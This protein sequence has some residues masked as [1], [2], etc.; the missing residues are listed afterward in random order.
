MKS[1]DGV[2]ATSRNSGDISDGIALPQSYHCS[3]ITANSFS[4]I[5]Q[6]PAAGRDF[7]P[8]DELP[9]SPRVALIGYSLWENRYG[10][11]TTVI[12]RTI[13]INAVPT[14]VI[15][16]MPRG[17]TF[18]GDADLWI[19]LVHTGEDPRRPYVTVFGHL[20]SGASMSG[21]R[22]EAS[23]IASRLAQ[24]FPDTNRNRT[25]VVQSYNEMA[26]GGRVRLVFWLMLAAVGFV[27]MIACANVANLLL[28][29]AVGRSREVSIRVALGASRLRVMRQLL[30]ESLLLSMVGGTLG[31]FLALWGTRAF[32]LAVIPTGKPAWVDFSLDY[33]VLLYLTAISFG[34]GILFGLVP[35]LRLSKA[36][37]SSALKEGG[38]GSSVGRRGHL[39]SGALVVTEMALA[40]VLLAGAGLM[41][42]SFLTVYATPVGVNTA[43]VF[44]MRTELPQAR[45]S[46]VEQQ[47]EFYQRLKARI[48]SLPAVESVTLLSQLPGDGML[49]WSYQLEG[50]SAQDAHLLP[51]GGLL[52]GPD[53]FRV[54]QVPLLSGRTFTEA[55]GVS[56]APAVIVNQSMANRFWPHENPVGKRLR[57]VVNQKEPP[58]P[59]LTVVGVAPDILQNNNNL[60]EHDPLIYLPYRERPQARM[61]IA[62]RTSVPPAT[63]GDVFRQ[64]VQAID[65][66]LPVR[67]SGTLEAQV[68]KRSWIAGVFG[69][70]FGIFG[71]IA[72]VLASVGLY[73]VMAHGVTQRTQEIGLRLAMGAKMADVLRLVFGQGMRQLALGLVIGVPAALAVTR[74]LAG[75]LAGVSPSDPLTYTSVTLILA[76]AGILGCAIPARRA[77]RVDPAITLRHE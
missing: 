29:R 44:T 60:I 28:A 16:V 50:V 8:E 3:E 21:A 48:E 52:I 68:A 5:G 12:G 55:D 31:W 1:F 40:V 69:A 13:R 67:E 76:A 77:V 34:T 51:H 25:F 24:Q 4:V 61:F 45:Y 2:A 36:D 59:W 75:V 23:T 39:L 47:I 35:A 42:R 38:R 70:M 41:L 6:K 54:M 14:V 18:P 43:G 19:P 57:L 71:T 33:R 72:F 74:A 10:K 62:A 46:R 15:G 11:D 27:L 73:A 63:L 56:G 17:I 58:Q 9:G 32:D 30:M 65:P 49:G 66:D 20:A 37:V 26:L 53:Y 64:A 22:A 7:T